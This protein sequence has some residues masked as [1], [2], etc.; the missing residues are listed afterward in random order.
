MKPTIRE[1]PPDDLDDILD[2]IRGL[3][4][5]ERMADQVTFDPAAMRR[6]PVRAGSR[7]PPCRSPRSTARRPG[8]RCGSGRS[9]RSSANRASGSRTSTCA[10]RTAAAASARRCCTTSARVDCRAASSGTCSTGTA[11]DRLLR[12]PRR[13]PRR[14][15]LDHVPLVAVMT[16]ESRPIPP[17]PPILSIAAD[18]RASGVRRLVA[19]ARTA[20]RPG[21]PG[22][23]SCS[24]GTATARSSTSGCASTSA[25]ASRPARS[26]AAPSRSG[27]SCS[28]SR[29]CCS[30]S[31]CS[32]SSPTSPRT[33]TP[34]RRH[35]RQPGR[36]I[37]TALTQPN[38]TRWIA[39]LVGFV[40][41]V[42]TGRSL[43]KVM[44]S[45]SCLAWRLPVRA[46][47]SVRVIGAVVGLIAGI[48]L[49]AAIVNRV[50]ADLGL[51]VAGVSFLVA[52]AIYVRGLDPPVDAA[53]R[54]DDRP[55][56]AAARGGD[57]RRR[58]SSGCRRSASCTCRTGSAGP[59]QLY[60]AI[61]TTIVTLGWF[62]ILGRAMVL[63]MAVNAVIYER[64]G[65]ISQFV[66]ALA[67]AARPAPTVGAD[68]ALLRT[69]PAERRRRRANL[70]AMT[71]APWIRPCR[72]T[73]S[74]PRRPS[75]PRSRCS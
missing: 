38:S 52:L 28:S 24:R 57:R 26:S 15:R 72:S 66:F 3:A 63:A 44:V 18:E 12:A 67:R 56:R 60:G 1:A 70:W 29:C 37:N 73:S 69:R 42:T 23:T 49:V 55:G 65:S 20:C 14:R 2:M 13:P 33:P 43:S 27:C 59:P 75:A 45:A 50:R 8:W 46:K 7:R 51:A 64:F 32:A 6:A 10:R 62:F 21:R 48:G 22:P 41:M 39:V 5:F 9:R 61:G 47:A 25:T 35:H 31:A 68:P 17:S 30:S 54:A 19:P 53:A 40:G 16:A 11:G 34:G 58:R 74:A 36:Q 4:E 71:T